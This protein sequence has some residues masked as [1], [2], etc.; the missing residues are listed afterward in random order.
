MTRDELAAVA[1]RLYADLYGVIVGNYSEGGGTVSETQNEPGAE[2]QTGTSDPAA[3]PDPRDAEIAS[4]QAQL[5][6]AQ[7]AATTDTAAAATP[8]AAPVSGTVDGDGVIA[9]AKRRL[10][11]GEGLDDLH[12][13]AIEHPDEFAG[14]QIAVDVE[15]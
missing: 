2:A 4:L 10:E 3:A 9:E 14:K 7:A 15:G 6:A 11:A 13:R 5:A 1:R 12:V 8:A